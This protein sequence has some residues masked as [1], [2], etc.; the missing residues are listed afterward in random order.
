MPP[1]KRGYL[2][3]GGEHGPPTGPLDHFEHQLRLTL[4]IAAIGLNEQI[5]I[6][7]AGGA[8]CGGRSGR[9]AET[10]TARA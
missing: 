7:L 2:G 8:S 3:V 5:H 10:G 4:G 6:P 1:P 9:L